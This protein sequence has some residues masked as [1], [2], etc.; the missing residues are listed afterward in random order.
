[1][2]DN[3][4]KKEQP[5]F[6]DR[7]RKLFSTAVL[8]RD[9]GSNKLKVI[10]IDK[11]QSNSNLQTNRMIDRYARVHVPAFGFGYDYSYSYQGTRLELYRDYEQMDTD[12]ILSSALDIFCEEAT[13][14]NSMGNVLEIVTD[15]KHIDDSLHNLFYDILNV[16]FNL[17]SWVRN[18]T[19]YGDMFL[20]LDVTEKIGVTNA[21]PLSV[22]GMF[23]SEDPNNP[24]VVKFKY[25]P[26]LGY[27]LYGQQSREFENYEI[28]HFRLLTDSNFLPYGRS[29]LE[30]ARTIWKEVT[31]LQDA[32]LIHRIMRAPEK[33]IFK[34]DIGGIP[35]QEVDTFMNQVVNKMKK[36]PYKDEKT[37]QYN[38]KFNLMPVRGNTKIPLIDGRTITI[39][40][41]AEETKSGKKNYVYSIDHN[42]KVVA[43]EVELCDLTMKDAEICR[44]I[45][46]DDSY[47]DFEPNHPVMLRNGEYKSAKDLKVTERLMPFNTKLSKEKNIEDYMMV[48]DPCTEK[49][50]HVHRRVADQ[51]NIKQE[52]KVIHHRDF[53]KLNNNPENLDGS[54][55]FV[56]HRTYHSNNQKAVQ[57]SRTK[58]EASARMTT[59]DNLRWKNEEY[60]TKVILGMSHFYDEYLIVEI[61]KIIKQ[62]DITSINGLEKL[63]NTNNNLKEYFNNLNITKKNCGKFT[64]HS[65]VKMIKRQGFLVDEYFAKIKEEITCNHRVKNVKILS[66]RDDVYCM[67]INDFHNFAIDSHGGT[68]L[69]GIYVK[70]SMME[71]FFIPV[72]GAN[73]GTSIEPLQGMEQHMVDDLNYLLHLMFAAL[74]IPRAFFGYEEELSCISPETVIPLWDGSAKTVLELID[75]YNNGNKNYVYSIDESTQEIVPGE[76]KWAGFTRMNTEVMNVILGNDKNI[77]CTPDHKFLT[78]TGEW[79]EAQNLKVGQSLM[80]SFTHEI[81]TVASLELVSDKCDT[82]DISIE[83]Y[84]NFATEA[85]VIIHNSKATLGSE[86]VRFAHTIERIQRIIESELYKIALVH[87]YAQG[88]DGEDLVSFSLKLT[89]SSEMP[90]RE[91]IES[92]TNK[93]DLIQKMMDSKLVSTE[94]IYKNILDM[95]T[96]EWQEEQKKLIDDLKVR[97]RMTQIQ[98]N[99]EDPLLSFKKIGSEEGSGNEFPE[100]G[101]FGEP[102]STEPGKLPPPPPLPA[103]IEPPKENLF[104]HKKGQKILKDSNIK[105]HT[106]L[107]EEYKIHTEFNDTGTFLDERVVEEFDKQIKNQ[108]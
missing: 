9:V 21:I 45:L 29:M 69:N 47:I 108:K 96:I 51:Y 35:P 57:A 13:L 79:I 4:P 92:Y 67:R 8:I 65:L 43:G 70:N 28:A 93:F 18:L 66:E 74:K 60:K 105:R 22:Y 72:R 50:V 84:Y 102:I 89:P 2:A 33:R 17:W 26:S 76:I 77:I 101:E 19:K 80:P 95:T 58:E 100:Q 34:V 90:Q 103:A 31:L 38:L 71:D 56:E 98:E 1:M 32:M 63:L 44:V 15:K 12:P 6:F 52:G 88:Y 83:N 62:N 14:R 68:N 48:L 73:S 49:Y 53:H 16:E 82:C 11:V 97:Y 99:G 41:L 3:A 39:K 81:I 25:D 37:G 46:D 107:S 7:L 20:K 87:L 27:Y 54:M 85:G 10:D 42:N 75:D 61:K 94:F 36:T 91:K 64:K 24:E 30:P 78:R 40:Q 86:S 59:E 23:R 104:R 55:T 5:Q 106:L